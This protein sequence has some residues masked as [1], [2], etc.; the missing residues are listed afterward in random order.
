MPKKVYK[1]RAEVW[2][3]PGYAGWHFVDLP[4]KLSQEIK[5]V[6]KSY[7]SGF[8]KIK[9]TIGKSSWVTALFPHKE[10]E[11]YLLSVKAGIRKKENIWEG[12][13]VNLDFILEK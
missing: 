12:D 8:I 9:A 6:G 3:W 5:K 1:F 2:K 11:T 10:S 7:G 13:K 4:K